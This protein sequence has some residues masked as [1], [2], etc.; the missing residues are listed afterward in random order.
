MV[1]LISPLA[2]TTVVKLGYDPTK[3]LFWKDDKW[4]YQIIVKGIDHHQKIVT[5]IYNT[6]D[7]I[8]DMSSNLRGRATRIYEAYEIGNPGSN[9]VIKDL[10]VDV[11]RTRYAQRTLEGYI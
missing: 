1:R 3:E 10:R 4:N 11:N 9:V 7:T 8:A 6:A 5:K 2:Y